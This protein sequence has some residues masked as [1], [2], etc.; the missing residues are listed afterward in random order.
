[1][2]LLSVLL[3]AELFRLKKYYVL[4]A[5]FVV[6]LLWVG[7]IY[8]AGLDA[9][10]IQLLPN[11]LFLDAFMMPTL[12]VGVMIFYEKQEG[13]AKSLFV[14][15]IS[16]TEVIVSKIITS[17]MVNST[18][19]ILILIYLFTLGDPAVA[20]S[21]N[22]LLLVVGMMICIIFGALLGFVVTIFAQD[23]TNLLMTIMKLTFLF[24]LPAI[25]YSLG[26]YQATWFG[27]MIKV[28]PTDAMLKVISHGLS[29]EQNIGD[30]LFAY[31]YL[32]V[33]IGL[34]MFWA[35]KRYDAYKG[36]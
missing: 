20:S 5:S 27:Y 24:A 26:I 19:L 10:V 12:V 35:S 32:L 6:A 1:M 30:V 3:K 25:I 36:V 2:K 13:T 29:I 16:K 18:T 7:I 4:Q 28:L 31:A 14:T 11:I 33:S 34:L 15:P 22:V 9:M 8:V 23:F 17:I 21:V